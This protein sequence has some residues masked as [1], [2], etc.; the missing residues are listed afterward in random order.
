MAHHNVHGV[1][2]HDAPSRELFDK[3]RRDFSSGCIRVKDPVDLAEWVLHADHDWP[4][5]RLERVIDSGNEMRVSLKQ[6]I[7][8]HILY[9]TVVSDNGSNEVRF[10][11]DIYDRDDRLLTALNARPVRR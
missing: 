3:T 7:P 4:R 2:L 1:Y 6:P 9:R 5:E 10:I 8:V 11:E